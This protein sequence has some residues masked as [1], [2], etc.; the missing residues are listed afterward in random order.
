MW[1]ALLLFVA[2]KPAES[3]H[4]KFLQ[5]FPIAP[6]KPPTTPLGDLSS[7]RVRTLLSSS[8]LT[9][10][11]EI[12][13]ISRLTV[14]VPHLHMQAE[15]APPLSSNRRMLQ[16]DPIADAQAI[17]GAL[18]KLVHQAGTA[19]VKAITGAQ[20]PAAGPAAALTP[21]FPPMSAPLARP[22]PSSMPAEAAAQAPLPAATTTAAPAFAPAFAPASAP[23]SGP[24]SESSSGARMWAELA[25]RTAA[26][27]GSTQAL[28]AVQVRYAFCL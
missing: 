12:P 20:T 7:L 4:R 23:A 19:L 1:L 18:G 21:A 26:A 22:A 14:H 15:Q 5:K 9:P 6:S 24:A 3:Q 28:Y 8:V 25:D 10:G 11:L 2:A 27:A 13:L 17:G 16:D